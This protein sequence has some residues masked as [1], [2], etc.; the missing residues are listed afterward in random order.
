MFSRLMNFLAISGFFWVFGLGGLICP[1]CNDFLSRIVEWRHDELVVDIFCEM[2]GE[3]NM[4]ISIPLGE[5]EFPFLGE[6]EELKRIAKI[7]VV[8]YGSLE[9]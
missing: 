7:K 6:G 3:Y 1:V 5:D 8:E 2:C 9:E 4:V